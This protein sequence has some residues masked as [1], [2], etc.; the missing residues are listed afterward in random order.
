MISGAKIGMPEYSYNRRMWEIIANDYGMWK[1]IQGFKLYNVIYAF[2]LWFPFLMI[3]NILGVERYTRL[4]DKI[5]PTESRDHNKDV[6]E[7]L[8]AT[9]D[10]FAGK[11][12]PWHRRQLI[13]RNEYENDT[14]NDVP[15]E[16]RK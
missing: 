8:I 1:E 2:I 3:R 7:R 14:S 11:P 12:E 5:R 15:P 4:V 9:Y 6:M 10:K 13:Y 16:G